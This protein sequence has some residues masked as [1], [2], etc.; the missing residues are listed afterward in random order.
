[1]FTSVT[2]TSLQVGDNPPWRL[3]VCVSEGS[4]VTFRNSSFTFF[5]EG[6]P[7]AVFHNGTSVL[8]RESAIHNNSGATYVGDSQDPR[9]GIVVEDASLSIVSST[10]AANTGTI[11]GSISALGAAQLH[12]QD[13]TFAHNS[14]ERGGAVHL[15]DQAYAVMRGGH[16]KG[17]RARWDGGCLFLNNQAQVQIVAGTGKVAWVRRGVV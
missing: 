4:A 3:G 9:G 5:N 2:L 10:I 8:L 6:T 14:G 12:I 13:T 16:C 11:S 1:M 7:L 17:N 15:T